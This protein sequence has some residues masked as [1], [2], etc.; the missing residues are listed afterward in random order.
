MASFSAHPPRFHYLISKT[1]HQR[2][3]LPIK[4][5]S[6]TSARGKLVYRA[7]RVLALLHDHE[8]LV[9]LDVETG[10]A[11]YR[12]AGAGGLGCQEVLYDV[13]FFSPPHH[14]PSLHLS[15]DTSDIRIAFRT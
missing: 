3:Q 10:H 5:L 6:V 1:D 4:P 8:D 13:S 14:P 2:T 9:V 12:V 11:E 7:G 15:Q